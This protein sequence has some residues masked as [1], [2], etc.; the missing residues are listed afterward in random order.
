MARTE[1]TC[2]VETPRSIWPHTVPSVPPRSPDRPHCGKDSAG[3]PPEATIGMVRSVPSGLP[4]P[5]SANGG[6]LPGKITAHLARPDAVVGLEILRRRMDLSRAATRLRAP[7]CGCRCRNQ[8]SGIR[9]HE[10]DP[11]CQDQVGSTARFPAIGLRHR[12]PPTTSPLRRPQEATE[13]GD[14]CGGHC[15]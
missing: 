3:L 11:G 10:Q 6:R 2:S 7:R 14:P 8:E 5:R 9:N 1:G 12:R 4:R 13:P 15:R